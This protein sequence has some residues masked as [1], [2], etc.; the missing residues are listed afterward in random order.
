MRHGAGWSDVF[1]VLCV[2]CV[3]LNAPCLVPAPSP[4]VAANPAAGLRTIIVGADVAVASSTL[5]RIVSVLCALCFLCVYRNVI[6]HQTA[7]PR[8]KSPVCMII[9][10]QCGFSL[11]SA[12]LSVCMSVALSLSAPSPLP[13][14]LS[15]PLMMGTVGFHRAAATRSRHWTRTSRTSCTW[16]H[17]ASRLR[18]PPCTGPS[19]RSSHCHS[20]WTPR[21]RQAFLDAH[22]HA[23]AHT[24]AAAPR[25][26]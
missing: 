6:W 5:S 18:Q 2:P 16:S 26:A 10:T 9:Q 1:V 17:L 21:Q 8:P 15:L 22:A 14:P 19:T 12:P 4:T 20:C 3:P 11:H 13:P 23:H 7:F 24:P 25:L